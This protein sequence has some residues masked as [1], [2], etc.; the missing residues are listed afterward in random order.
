MANVLPAWQPDAELLAEIDSIMKE[1]RTE[2]RACL[3]PIVAK[4][5][6]ALTQ[7]PDSEYRKMLELSTKMTMVGRACTEI[8][9]HLFDTRRLRISGLFGACCFLGDSFT[10]D[11][12]HDAS[13]EYVQRLGVLIDQGWFEVRNE[14]E[15]LFAAVISRLF[16]E[17]DVLHPMLRQAITH[18]FFAQKKDVSLREES[19]GHAQL[20]RRQHLNTLKACARDRSGHAIT[21]LSLFL[22]PD[23]PMQFLHKIYM[24]GS[25]IMF[26]DDHGDCYF[27]R[28][29]K[30]VTYMNQ[31]KHPA[32]IL[33]RIFHRNISFLYEGLP[34]SR[35]RDLLIGFLFRY[36]VT[37]LKKHQLE[38]HR[39]QSA[40]AVYE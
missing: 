23:F 25:L 32:H 20:S 15:R 22:V 6:P 40:W 37:R 4:H 35:G 27:D 21:A 2:V 26:I 36:Y 39:G 28:F 8:A 17:R 18:L 24:A 10:D 38:R 12:G 9:G 16:G 5:Y 7:A 33:R 29:S 13:T 30:R 14:R 3:A 11:F 1:Q 19:G 31:V 34:P